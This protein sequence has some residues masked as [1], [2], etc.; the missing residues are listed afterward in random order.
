MPGR[1]CPVKQQVE[2]VRRTKG[3]LPHGI[4]FY[5]AGMGEDENLLRKEIA[6]STQ[7]HYVGFLNIMEN[8]EKYDYVCLFS[9]KEGLPLSLIEGLMFGKPLLT[10][11]LPAVLDVN[12]PGETGFAF[13]DFEALVNGL[14]QLPKP[15]DSEYARLSRSARKRYEE[16]FTE[17]RMIENYRHVILEAMEFLKGKKHSVFV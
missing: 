13:P 10:N 1:I 15:G 17:E 4:H 6:C 2:L 16:I 9:Q 11:M 8:L 7:Y 14:G 12:V 3:K 5:F